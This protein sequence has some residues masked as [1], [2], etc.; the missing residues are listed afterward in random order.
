MSGFWCVVHG[1]FRKDFAK[2][3]AVCH[4][5]AA[6]GITVLAPKMESVVAVQDGFALFKDEIGVDP[7]LI[8]L[9]YLHLLK[10]LGRSGFSYFVNPQGTLGTSASYELAIAQSNNVPCFFLKQ[11]VDHPAYIAC[12]A[13]MSVEQLV[14]YICEFD[15][16]PPPWI[17]KREKQLHQ[18]S[19]ELILPGSVVAAGAM[20][21]FTPRRNGISKREILLVNT[22]KWGNRYSIVGGKVRRNE[23]LKD[24]L[25]R[26]VKEETGAKG[27]IGA[28]LCTFDQLERSGYYRCSVQHIFSDFVVGVFSRRVRL[29]DEAQSYLWVR[30]KEALEQLD[31]EPNARETLKCYVE[32]R[33]RIAG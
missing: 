18:L 21:E 6:A 7:R 16:L 2:I 15:L 25:L 28:H 23:L 24:A 33:T 10:K 32:Y 11:L 5:F 22:H 29:N 17:P 26:E 20:I 9:R 13:V 14:G 8:E 27:E 19:R 1:S 31:I 3:Q 4:A 30:P 12:N